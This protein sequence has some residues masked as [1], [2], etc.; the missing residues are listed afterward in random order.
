MSYDAAV[1][2]ALMVALQ[3]STIVSA[4]HFRGG[5][6]MLRPQPGGSGNEVS[7]YAAAE[8][9]NIMYSMYIAIL[10]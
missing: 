1:Q 5:I 4:S 8:F 6:F 2:L 10:V 9:L 3:F 7:I